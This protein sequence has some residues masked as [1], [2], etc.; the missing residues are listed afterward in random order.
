M[1]QKYPL[2]S[3]PSHGPWAGALVSLVINTALHV[4]NLFA[5]IDPP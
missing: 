5:N 4:P 2:T 1:F 3:T